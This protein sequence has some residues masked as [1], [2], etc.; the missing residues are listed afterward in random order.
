MWLL[1]SKI[2]Q[3]LKKF[4]VLNNRGF[5]TFPNIKNA[6][7][8]F[9]TSNIHFFNLHNSKLID[10]IPYRVPFLRGGGVALNEFM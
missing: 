9:N 7:V 1:C 4:K 3:L 2:Q 6:Q 10:K 5:Y 8:N